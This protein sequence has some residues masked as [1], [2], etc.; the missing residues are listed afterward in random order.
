MKIFFTC[1][2]AFWLGTALAQGPGRQRGQQG[3]TPKK[4]VGKVVDNDSGQPLEYASISLFAQRDSSLVTG[5]IT[6]AKGRFSIDIRPGRFYALVQF[7]SYRQKVIRGIAI[8]PGA[9]G[10]DMGEIRLAADVET[11]NEVVVT[12]EKDQM[13]MTLDKRVF[14]VGKDLSNSG[15]TAE[16]ILDNVPS[17]SVDQDGNVSLRGSENVRILVDGKPSG[18]IGISSS[19]GLRQL[20]GDIIE[21][22][23]VVTNPSARYDAE[24][25][26]GIINIILKKDRESGLN[27][28]FTL[29][30]GYPNNQG[31]SGNFNFR[32]KQ[33][34]FFG[35]YGF[36][37]RESPGNASS[38]Q[39][40]FSDE[41][42]A[43]TDQDT[44]FTRG[45]FS[46]NFRV[47][48]EWLID[49]SSSLSGAF[50][51]R[52]SDGINDRDTRYRDFDVTNALVSETL[53][54]EEE[55]EED[56]NLEYSLGY[57]KNFKK[58]GQKLTA[59][60]QYRDNS[61]I[62]K[63]DIVE[64]LVFSIDNDADLPPSQR[65]DNREGETSWLV[66]ADYVHPLGG[67]KSFE[68]GYR[69]NL[70]NLSND[71]LVET[72][73]GEGWINETALSN[74][75]RYD[76]D[77]HAAYAIYSD[78][79]EK[80]SYQLG[81]RVEA[82]DINIELL[83]TDESFPK[84]YTN[85]FPSAFFTYTIREGN[86]L[87]A[88]YSRRIRRPRSR[89]LNPFPFT[90]G[91]NRNLRTG[92]PDLDPTFTDSYEM[93]YLRTWKKATLFSSIYYRRTEGV[94]QRITTR[95]DS[96]N[97]SMP[98]NLSIENAYGFEFNY[99]HELTS[100]WRVNGNANLYRAVIDGGASDQELDS[101]TYTLNTRLNSRITLWN[102][103]ESQVNFRYRAPE[104]RPQGD[105]RSF[106]MLDLGW[107]MN[108]FDKKGT[109]VFNIRDVF[110]TGIYRY[111]TV[112]E[113]F[114]FDSEFQRRVRSYTLSFTYR[115]NQKPARRDRERRNREG[116]DNFEDDF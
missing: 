61:E 66:Q 26:A 48:A 41:G 88:S 82:T 74:N 17:V 5:G 87:Q 6:N 92:N 44:D 27:G 96:V 77:V 89:S 103:L 97:I 20:Q 16:D 73:T 1:C 108:A 55:D 60:I 47:G 86:S 35:N 43:I 90:I 67:F 110:N 14:N 12:A 81:L 34:N 106:Y 10:Y 58:K 62:E 94:V 28:S 68:V 84:S 9:E 107:S 80:I 75:F 30:T 93:G 40:F 83:Q 99:S 76:E 11:L 98:V 13:E 39:R 2:L 101:D 33:V 42:T 78:K 21:S 32:Q 18:L 31:A 54:V 115:I 57:S 72:L 65:S 22:I 36:R 49:E 85:L 19:D 102:K 7:I 111:T 51:Y 38:F 104:V 105:R 59:D 116:G 69:A 46:N 56:T 95:M 15:R 63:A 4:L 37:Y 109:F 29:D 45:G 23:E 8:R 52:V 100:W 112:D 25:N 114:D 79:F 71:Y 50:L 70:R 113:D 64:T 53:R 91:D 24:G 3:F